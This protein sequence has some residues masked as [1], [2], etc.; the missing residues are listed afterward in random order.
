M[1]LTNLD[2]SSGLIGYNIFGID[3]SIPYEQ[4]ISN[5][6]ADLLYITFANGLY[7]IDLGWSPANDAQGRFILRVI[8]DH[9][10]EQPFHTKETRSFAELMLYLQAYIYLVVNLI[11]KN[12]DVLKSIIVFEKTDIRRVYWLID[13]YLTNKIS[14]DIFCNE[15][16]VCYDLEVDK[17]ILTQEEH[18]AFSELSTIAGRCSTFAE[19]HINLPGVYYTEQDLKNKVNEVKKLLS[20]EQW[21]T[22]FIKT[23]L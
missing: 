5:L 10:W 20:T 18:T 6:D 2:F 1:T 9:N 7:V 21:Q 3:P 15:F 8:K 14:A 13:L 16:Y 17:D 11:D 4:Q 12:K 22:Q 23:M 19:D